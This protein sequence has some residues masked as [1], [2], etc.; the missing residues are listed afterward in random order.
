M[1]LH[2]APLA[3]KFLLMALVIARITLNVILCQMSL[4]VHC[5]T[6]QTL[7]HL[8]NVYAPGGTNIVERFESLTTCFFTSEMF[9]SSFLCLSSVLG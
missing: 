5:K 8:D 2:F 7:K 3:G 6:C 1:S 4:N 9:D